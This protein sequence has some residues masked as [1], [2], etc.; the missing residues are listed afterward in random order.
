[1]MLGMEEISVSSWSR[2]LRP[3]IRISPLLP[4]EPLRS[5]LFLAHKVAP[6]GLWSVYRRMPDS[7][8]GGERPHP[9]CV[10]GLAAWSFPHS[11][12]AGTPPSWRPCAS[13]L[14]TRSVP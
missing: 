5:F 1:M 6:L 10:N 14:A 11:L 12:H 7:A 13:G 4:E 9:A 2:Y 8:I 3:V